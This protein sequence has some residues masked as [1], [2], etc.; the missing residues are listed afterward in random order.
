MCRDE[1]GSGT[2]AIVEHPGPWGPRA[3]WQ[4][5]SSLALGA[6]VD[7]SLRFESGVIHPEG[8]RPTNLF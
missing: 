2:S 1:C 5:L 4:P 7:R 6:V 3:R 8:G